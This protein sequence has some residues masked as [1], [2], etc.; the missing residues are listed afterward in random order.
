MD[1]SLEQLIARIVEKLQG[2]AKTNEDEFAYAIN[3]EVQRNGRTRFVFDV[4]ETAD[5]HSFLTGFG[6]TIKAA[7]EDAEEGIDAA[8]KEW[9]YEK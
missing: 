7:V 4:T 5:G 2:I 6:E 3:L 9:G 1:E 8:C